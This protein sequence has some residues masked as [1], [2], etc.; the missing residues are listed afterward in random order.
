MVSHKHKCIFIH[1]PKAAGTSIEMA[2]LDDL[3]LDMDN[4]HALLL[5]ENTNKEL[6]PRRVSHLTAS[7][8]VDLHFVSKEIYDQYFTFSFVRHPINRLYS[9]Y[10]YRAFSDYISFD[11][12]IKMKLPQ[13]FNSKREG[14]FYKSQY[15]YIYSNKKRNVDFIGEL[16]NLEKDF[17]IVK[18][19]TGVKSSLKHYNKSQ[20]KKTSIFKKVGKTLKDRKAWMNFD[21][22]LKDNYLSDEAKDIVLKYYKIDFEFFNYRLSNSDF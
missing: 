19:E 22:T 2:F 18:D 5:G 6:G 9:T 16:N 17:K 1:I 12:F 14:F 20:N 4:R 11:T 13:L 10:K 21:Y 3:G 15:D 7:E 8:Y